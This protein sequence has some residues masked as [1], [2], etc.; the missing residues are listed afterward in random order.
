M[1]LQLALAVDHAVLNSARSSHLAEGLRGRGIL[2]LADIGIAVARKSKAP[3]LA[4]FKPSPARRIAAGAF[5]HSTA[6]RAQ[7]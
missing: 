3:A 6:W 7:A 4:L 1:L 5:G 2:E